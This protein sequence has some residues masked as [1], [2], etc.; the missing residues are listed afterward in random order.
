[1]RQFLLIANIDKINLCIID[2]K[3]YPIYLKIYFIYFVYPYFVLYLISI[4]NYIQFDN[5]KKNDKILFTN[6]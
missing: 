2:I 6:F 5:N 3:K 1:M 4:K